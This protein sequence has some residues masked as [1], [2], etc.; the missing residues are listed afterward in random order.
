MVE[1]MDNKRL[2]EEGNPNLDSPCKAQKSSLECEKA[3]TG[4]CE[5]DM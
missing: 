2:T 5:T 3:G 4:E 1:E